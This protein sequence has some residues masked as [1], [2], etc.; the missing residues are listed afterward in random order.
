[1]WKSVLI[2]SA[3]QMIKMINLFFPKNNVKRESIKLNNI[4]AATVMGLLQN[5]GSASDFI[6]KL[7]LH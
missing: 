2:C 1:M 3:G 5:S 6:D 7:Q 4:T